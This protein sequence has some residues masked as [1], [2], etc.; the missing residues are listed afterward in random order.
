MSDVVIYHPGTGGQESVPEEG[1]PH[2]RQSGW[3]LLSEHQ[4][5]E[6]ART[7]REA[8]ETSAAASKAGKAS[9]EGDR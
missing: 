9:K 7:E 2:Y 1:L 3:L 4:E 6:A 5:N 8:A